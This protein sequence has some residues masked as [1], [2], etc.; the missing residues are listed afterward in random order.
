MTV[1][2]LKECNKKA[3]AQSEVGAAVTQLAWSPDDRSLAVGTE[4]G[5]VLVYAVG[6]VL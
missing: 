2:S 5:G 3:L 1:E 4:V 6:A